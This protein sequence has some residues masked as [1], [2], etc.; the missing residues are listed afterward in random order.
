MLILEGKKEKEKKSKFF[1][2]RFFYISTEMF[3]ENPS[4]DPLTTLT[5]VN[6]QVE[7]QEETLASKS[8]I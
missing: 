4:I 3:L 5:V 2:G 7:Y 8:V 1:F 6:Y